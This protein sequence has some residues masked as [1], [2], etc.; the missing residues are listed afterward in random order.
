LLAF[1]WLLPVGRLS[2][3]RRLHVPRK[4]ATRLGTGARISKI[5]KLKRPRPLLK[6]C[7]ADVLKHRTP[8]AALHA[9]FVAGVGRVAAA[10]GRRRETSE[11]APASVRSLVI[12]PSRSP[13]MDASEPDDD[14]VLASPTAEGHAHEVDH[15][16]HLQT[17]T[18]ASPARAHTPQTP[19]RYPPRGLVTP[20][21][22]LGL[23]A[24]TDSFL[25]AL[26][27]N[28]HG[29]DFLEFEIQDYDTGERFFRIQKDP[30]DEAS[31]NAGFDATEL[32][33]ET[34][35]LLRTV[36]YAFPRR[37]LRSRAIRTALTFSVGDLPANDFRLVE[38]HYFENELLRSY[39]FTFGFCVPNS[40]NGWEAIYP[41]PD[42]LRLDANGENVLERRMID[43]PFETKSDSFYFVGKNL[44]MHN[45][46]AYKYE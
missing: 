6:K 12:G 19:T 10:R 17:T 27:A 20:E 22:V 5:S 41:L 45:K 4:R 14:V 15:A 34:E 26:S 43:A 44:V 9:R 31:A 23:T 28:V 24:P 13:A 16:D 36:R 3:D 25:C 29:F 1:D 42:C 46:A 30:T 38:R 8:H 7:G 35:A 11:E 32:S 18:R 40:T 33:L 37:V 21:Y 39:D 2:V